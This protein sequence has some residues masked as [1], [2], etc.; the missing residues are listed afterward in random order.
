MRPSNATKWWYPES[1]CG[2]VL[3]KNTTMTPDFRR[4]HN[5]YGR[6]MRYSLKEPNAV[7][8]EQALKD[9]HN[10]EL[11]LVQDFEQFTQD[12]YEGAQLGRTLRLDCRVEANLYVAAQKVAT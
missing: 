8:A 7:S 9:Q 5:L 12:V 2:G 1:S 6:R 3:A 10:F 11:A 4:V